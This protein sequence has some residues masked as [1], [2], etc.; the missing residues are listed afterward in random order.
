MAVIVSMSIESYTLEL[1][2]FEI[3]SNYDKI[4]V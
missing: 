4:E 2:Y 3:F 1:I